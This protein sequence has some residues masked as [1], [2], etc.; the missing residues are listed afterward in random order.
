MKQEN[1]ATNASLDTILSAMITNAVL[2]FVR[3]VGKSTM[4]HHISV[5]LVSSTKRGSVRMIRYG[6]CLCRLTPKHEV[7]KQRMVIPR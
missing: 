7:V 3:T 1:I 6:K 2:S 5:S 4:V